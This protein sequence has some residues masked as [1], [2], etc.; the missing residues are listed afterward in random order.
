MSTHIT[1]I[2]T[3]V[4]LLALKEMTVFTLIT[5]TH[6]EGPFVLV[7][8]DSIS[9]NVWEPLLPLGCPLR[10]HCTILEHSFLD[11]AGSKSLRAPPCV[12]LL[13]VLAISSSRVNFPTLSVPCST[14]TKHLY[15]LDGLNFFFYFLILMSGISCPIRSNIQVREKEIRNGTSYGS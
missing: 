4:Y 1:Y 2:S 3:N 6:T 15:T 11:T 13:M 14:E 9:E 7:Y 5:C 8:F 12:L 10:I